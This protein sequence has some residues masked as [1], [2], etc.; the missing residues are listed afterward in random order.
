[1]LT[2]ERIVQTLRDLAGQEVKQVWVH[3]RPGLMTP[4]LSE[5]WF[6]LWKAAVEEAR[7]LDMNVWIYDENSYPSGF[8]GGLVPEAMPESRG[9]GLAFREEPQPKATGDVVAI[10]RIAASTY[11]EVTG[12]VRSGAAMPEARYLVAYVLRAADTP[13]TAGK[14]YVDLLYPGVT[15][16]FLE[17]TLEAYRREVGDE[18][19]RHVPGVFT[20][21]P[22]IRPAG[23]LPWTED[24]PQQFQR[25][26]GYSLTEHLPALVLPWGDWKRV[27]HNYH[28][29]LLELFVERWGKPYYEY[30]E[31]NR[32]QLTGHYWEHEWPGCHAV[33]DNMAMYAW[34][35][36]PGIDILFND[37]GEGVNA[38]FGNVRA[39]KELSSVANQLGRR[40]TISETYAGTGWQCRFEDL[41]RIG[42]WEF[43]L[44]VNML[45]EC[46]SFVTIRGV[47]K[48]DYPQSL[49]YHEPWWEAYH[50]LAGYF[51]RLSVAL[52]QGEQVNETL[53]IEPTT[54]AWMYQPDKELARI[55]ETF[56]TLVTRLAQAQAPYDIGSEYVIARHGSVADGKLVVGRRR[57]DTVVLPPHC[58]NL[59]ETTLS[60]LE[61]FLEQGG[62]LLSCGPT[63]TLVDGRASDRGQAM[64]RSPTW[65]EVDPEAVVGILA[66]RADDGFAIRR[67][68]LDSGIL[69]SQRRRL[70]DGDLLFLVNT[71]DTSKSTGVV[72]SA[73]RGV[74]RW[75]PETGAVEPFA[76]TR[77]GDSVEVPFDLPPC[78]SLLLFLGRE[79][80]EA[81]QAGRMARRVVQSSGPTEV[82]RLAPNVL[83][84]DYVDVAAGGETKK[85]VHTRKAADFV[86]QQNGLDRNP[87]F[88]AVQFGDEFIKL[89]FPPQS[90]FTATYRFTIREEIPKRLAMVIERADL[91]AITCNGSRVSGTPGDWWLDRSFGKI[92]L[93][94]AARI[95][96][97]EVTINASPFT[98]FHE[99][100]PAY[101]LGDFAL[102]ATDSGFT[103]VPE[104]PIGP[105]AEARPDG[106]VEIAPW[107]EQGLPFYAAGVS[108]GQTF[109]VP[110][111]AGEYHVRLGRWYGSVVKIVVNG[112]LAGYLGYRPY[113]LDVTPWITPGENRV[114]VIVIGTLKNTLGPHHAGAALP[115]VGPHSFLQAP[116][117]GP[118]PGRKYHTLGYGLF[119][120]FALEQALWNPSN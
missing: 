13:W 72:R 75:V 90:G 56:Q 74:E 85:S 73:A 51:T 52:S 65:R 36:L 79:S 61:A 86:F 38:Q 7:R 44:G 81:K 58:E 25:R 62:R 98:L 18:F 12:E 19:G 5:D 66:D 33:P 92:D 69:Y 68:P 71:S 99:L 48:G 30:C 6:R 100:E 97:N 54:T 115:Y 11:E 50:L 88:H 9:R 31:A 78:G 94:S 42:D 53:L 34:Q 112:Q 96:E 24:L 47:R 37:Y 23:G 3:P 106:G 16:K 84:L 41:K 39:V 28:Q 89:K 59:N 110:R 15:E 57:Y 117:V 43:A 80:M 29:I 76:F 60:L 21:E 114:E 63:P 119:E 40:R 49:S 82:H 108:Y 17:I 83:T 26:F 102:E 22:Q 113:D 45:N 111:P 105:T 4:Y 104:K 101:L 14:C 87:W 95:G 64:A 2:E 77:T 107:N 93:A 120:P 91:Y 8:A 35:Q 20:D 116:A 32:L 67:D 10:Y 1:M 46:I 70:D 103:V 118:P 27:R 109:Q 55:G